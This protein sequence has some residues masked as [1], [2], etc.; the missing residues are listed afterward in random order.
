[1]DLAAGPGQPTPKPDYRVPRRTSGR[2]NRHSQDLQD[3][4]AILA[5]LRISD[6]WHEQELAEVAGTRR[7]D[8]DEGRVVENDV[9]GDAGGS[10][11][12]E[13]PALETVDDLV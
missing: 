3:L 7:R 2:R 5:Q 6:A 9:G 8:R 11:R 1:M 10:R 12:F 13:T 4:L